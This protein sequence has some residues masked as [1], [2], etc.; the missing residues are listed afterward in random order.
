MGL[1]SCSGLFLMFCFDIKE[2]EDHWPKIQETWV[3][4]LDTCVTLGMLHNLSVPQLSSL[5]S[6][7]STISAY[8]AIS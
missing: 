7:G 1:S 2:K 3:L 4:V 5:T 8:P 6:G